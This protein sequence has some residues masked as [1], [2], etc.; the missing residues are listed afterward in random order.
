MAGKSWSFVD[1]QVRLSDFV[2]FLMV[3]GYLLLVWCYLVATRRLHSGLSL[4]GI[5]RELGR[6]R[7]EAKGKILRLI[8]PGA[9]R[10][11]A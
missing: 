11:A 7:R 8:R 5:L 3:A 10:K 2:C 4:D 9:S 6:W 1:P